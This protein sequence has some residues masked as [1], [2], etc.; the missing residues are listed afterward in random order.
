MLRQ[1]QFAQMSNWWI[2]SKRTVRHIDEGDWRR[3]RHH[4]LP[5]CTPWNWRN[6]TY[7]V[8]FAFNSFKIFWNNGQVVDRLPRGL[9]SLKIAVESSDK[10]SANMQ[11][12]KKLAL[13]TSNIIIKV[14]FTMAQ[15][16]IGCAFKVQWYSWPV[17]CA[18]L[19]R[20]SAINYCR[21]TQLFPKIVVFLAAS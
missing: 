9:F 11:N 2:H 15:A 10:C 8:D 1:Q 16:S 12:L 7:L 20:V 19:Y 4:I 3:K 21:W 13:R 5:P 18:K 6:C 14:E 17:I